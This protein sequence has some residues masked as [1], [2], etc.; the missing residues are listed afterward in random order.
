MGRALAA[1][2]DRSAAVD[3]LREAERELDGCRLRARAR[4]DAPRAA[5]ARRPRETRGPATGEDAGLDALTKREREIADLVTDRKT[6]S[7]IAAAALPE[8]AR[9]SSRTC[10]TSSSS[11]ASPRASRWRA[12]SSATAATAAPRRAHRDRRGR[13]HRAAAVDADAARLRELGY[14]QEL[15]RGLRVSTTSRSASPRSRRSSASTPS[16]SSGRPSPGRPGSGCCRSRSSASACCSPSTRSSPRE[17]PI[18]GGAYQWSRRLIGG[19][20]GWFGGWVA[21]CAYAVANTTIAYLG[22]PW[23]LTLLEIDATPHGDRARPAMALVVVC[24]L[25]GAIGIELLAR[26]V[27]AGIAAEIARLGRD[28]RSRCC[29]SSA[30]RTSRSSARRSAPRRSPAARPAPAMLAALAVGGWVFIGFDACVGAAEETRDAARHVPRAIWIALLSVGAL[31]IL[32][33]VAVTLA[34]PDPA[35][36]RRGRG[37]STRSRPPSSARSAPGRRSRSPPSCSSRSSPAASRR[38][39]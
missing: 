32:N 5:Q 17:F 21:I 35:G 29:S 9:R 1:A 33:A 27:K 25:V 11:S 30:S 36:R 18:A 3:A 39:R 10:A 12:R 6:N 23:A 16:C 15:D 14:E 4:R 24:A 34:H 2:G 7:E 19:A 22:A 37:R 13:Q 28:R 26:V 31:V 8:R 20:Y 38:R